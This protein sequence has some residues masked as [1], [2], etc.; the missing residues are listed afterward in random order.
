[1]KKNYIAWNKDG[2]DDKK[3]FE[4]LRLYTNGAINITDK[5]IKTGQGAQ[6]HN[7]RNN[8]RNNGKKQFKKKF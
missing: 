3:I 6:N 1:M 5:E 8:K 2:V 7:Q 4:D